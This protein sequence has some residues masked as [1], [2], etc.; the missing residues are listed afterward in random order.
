MIIEVNDKD[1]QKDV[2]D[3]SKDIPILV[4]F[5]APWCQPCLL[6]GPILEKLSGEYPD[7]FILAKVNVQE[8]PIVASRFGI[9][10]IPTVMLFKN[11]KVAD[12]FTGVI[13]E[14][15]IKEWGYS[16]D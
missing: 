16:L 10:A 9:S 11:G 13:P 15:E 12:E 1:F 3:K 14:R 2:V 8:N 7:K 5:W 6:L 4:D